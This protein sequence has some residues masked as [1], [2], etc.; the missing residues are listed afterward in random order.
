[1][2]LRSKLSGRQIEAAIDGN[3][4]HA[5]GGYPVLVGHAGED[6]F[7]IPWL[8]GQMY[9]LTGATEEEWQRLVDAGYALDEAGE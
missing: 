3:V 1:M 6:S 2:Q 4:F 9:E 7:L 8:D 5:S